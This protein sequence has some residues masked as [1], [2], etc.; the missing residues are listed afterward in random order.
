M[1]QHAVSAANASP[2]A[3][4]TRGKSPRLTP[5]RIFSSHLDSIIKSKE[6]ERD[7]QSQRRA[8]PAATAAEVN[9]EEETD[10]CDPAYSDLHLQERQEP[11]GAESEDVSFGSVK[12]EIRIQVTTE[13]HMIP[14]PGEELQLNNSTQDEDV[15][16]IANED[17]DDVPLP[18]QSPQASHQKNAMEELEGE[19]AAPQRKSS[20]SKKHK[21]RKVSAQRNETPSREVK[22]HSRKSRKSK[23]SAHKEE[24]DSPDRNPSPTKRHSRHEDYDQTDDDVKGKIRIKLRGEGSFQHLNKSVPLSQHETDS[25]S[26]PQSL[27]GTSKDSL[28]QSWSA[29][30]PR[31]RHEKRG[32]SSHKRHNSP[33]PVYSSS[34][35]STPVKTEDIKYPPQQLKNLNHLARMSASEI[36]V[37][38]AVSSA[39]DDEIFENEIFTIRHHS[40]ETESPSE[41]SSRS[42]SGCSKPSAAPDFIPFCA[43]RPAYVPMRQEMYHP[44]AMTGSP[45]APNWQSP[46]QYPAS[47][48]PAMLQ[49]VFQ[50]QDNFD[51]D[52]IA[53]LVRY[54]P[55]PHPQRPLLGD[56]PLTPP[57]TVDYPIKRRS[58]PPSQEYS[59]PPANRYSLPHQWLQPQS[60][61][62][63]LPAAPVVDKRFTCLQALHNPPRPSIFG[64][65]LI[66]DSMLLRFSQQILGQPPIL[67]ESIR[68][69]GYCVSGQRI[70]DLLKRLKSGFYHIGS[71]VVLM[72]GTNDLVKNC[73]AEQMI[74]EL[75]R[76]LDYLC[77]KAE[78]IVV[79]TLPPV[80][81][82]E[83]YTHHWTRL[84]K[85]NDFIRTLNN[86]GPPHIS[87]L[88]ICRL[89]CDK[90]ISKCRMDCFEL[91][92]E[93][94]NR[95]DLIHLNRK[96]LLLVKDEL[97]KLS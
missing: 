93:S 81:L 15:D 10:S 64:Y 5:N 11:Y 16:S 90:R 3:R 33:L 19:N 14:L 17:Q 58:L 12:E 66:G 32:R 59:I 72:I 26:T 84:N 35:N 61:A 60:S 97:Y 54:P 63:L 50:W 23:R 82:Q 36:Y 55:P 28:N 95:K 62:E 69:L 75:R 34:E 92:F 24:N 57:G 65:Q 76:V 8:A 38:V 96:G 6:K 30:T 9:A 40:S 25:S 1:E 39:S 49:G 74:H 89:Y 7:V 83:H 91:K 18:E 20:K 77:T 56:L 87:H 27:R 37:D 22:T 52:A 48:A 21:K 88:D 78:K 73:Q 80:P 47:P 79:L 45:Y 85:Y 43:P 53:S 86:A 29:E 46:Q 31:S 2:P 51:G 94:S 4:G 41:M 71:K 42:G 67:S 68:F 44:P 13:V 70:G